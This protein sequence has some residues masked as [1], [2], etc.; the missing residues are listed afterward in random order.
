MSQQVVRV[1]RLP[2]SELVWVA[3][4]L[5]SGASEESG[6]GDSGGVLT[7]CTMEL[8]PY[9][10]RVESGDIAN[11]SDGNGGGRLVNFAPLLLESALVGSVSRR[12]ARLLGQ[13]AGR[14]NPGELYGI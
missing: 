10:V 1:A 7:A 14:G 3:R 5:S 9:V 2:G 12:W 6:S 13:E 8:C 11:S 4:Q